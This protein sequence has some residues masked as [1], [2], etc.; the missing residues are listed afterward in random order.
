M[1]CA[2]LRHNKE[3]GLKNTAPGAKK[4]SKMGNDKAKRKSKRIEVSYDIKVRLVGLSD[5]ISVVVKDI[6]AT[7]ARIIISG[8][9]VQVG[10][11]VEARM[12]INNRDIQ[13]NG[14][15]V[16][17][18]MMRPSLGNVTITDVGIEFQDMKEE[19]KKFLSELVGEEP[20]N[21]Q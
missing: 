1:P 2:F 9:V 11:P 8:R 7:G 15:V 20:L 4:D 21:R 17:A 3:K 14:K 16:W 5:F 18:L 19:D 12:S 13:C 10:Q 6:S